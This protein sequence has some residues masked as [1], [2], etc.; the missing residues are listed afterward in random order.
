MK[1]KRLKIG[2]LMGG[3]SS[4]R[5]VSL[6]SGRAIA[7]AL[8]R[9]GF[10]VSRIDLR[11]KGHRPGPQEREV[12]K[13]QKIKAITAGGLSEYLKKERFDCI[14]LALHGGIGENG[15][16]QGFLEVLGIPYTGS[17]I[18]ASSLAM[19]KL[20]SK[21]L[22]TAHGLSVPEFMII[23]KK[24]IP[25]EKEII[26]RFGLPLVVKPVHEGSSVGVTVVD[27]PEELVHAIKVAKEYGECLIE[28]Y[29]KGKEVHVGILKNRAIGAVEVRPKE[30]FY[31]YRAKYTQGMTEYIIPPDIP[32]DRLQR[33]LDTGLLA[34]RALDCSGATRVDLIITDKG[35]T[36]VLEV[37]TIPGMTETSL[38]PKIARS[39]GI[40]FEELVKE[41]LFDALQKN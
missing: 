32:Q 3:L 11:Q 37:N 4:E 7:D 13:N 12:L 39:A 18:K 36:Y 6:R 26:K 20:A 19:D 24:E 31:S 10:K 30:R 34:H 23:E 5:E 9:L 29:I 2:V 17:G 40:T 28:E 14:F 8:E 16:I 27:R 38:L 1:P 41:I 22:F 33:A 25:D 15:A 21:R 35:E